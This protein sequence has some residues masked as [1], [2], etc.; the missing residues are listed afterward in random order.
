MSSPGR[1]ALR[2]WRQF[3][4]WFN[5]LGL[6]ENAVLLAFG[7]A[8]GA[9]AALGVLGFYSLMDGAYVFF[10]DT[11]AGSLPGNDLDLYRPLLTAG[12]LAG[13]WWIMRRPGRGYDGLNIPDVQLAVARRGGHLPVRPALARTAASAI[14]IGGGGSAGSE[15]PVA[16][17]GST[18]GSFLGRVFRFGPARVRILVAAGAAGGIS[19]AFNAPLAG[20]FFALEQVLGSLAAEAFAPVVVS[21]VTAAVLSHAFFGT[22]PALTAPVEHAVPGGL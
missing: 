8:V 9:L 22:S 5:H 10:F 7:L 1:R 17:V 21:S 19:A 20:A 3:T 18:V 14:T 16:V 13:A 11:V 4:R 12:A 2:S 6:S 15:G